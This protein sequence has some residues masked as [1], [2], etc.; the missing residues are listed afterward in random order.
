[1]TSIFY[2]DK[3]ENEY[4]TKVLFLH[5]LEGSSTGS[6]A[7]QLKDSWGAKC[8]PLRT[9]ELVKLKKS[10]LKSWLELDLS[11]IENSMSDAIDDAKDAIRYFQ[12]DIIIGSSMGAA[13]L[14]KLCLD[15]TI[16]TDKT[17]CVFLAP[18]IYELIRPKKKLDLE[19]SVWIFAE[20]DEAVNNRENFNIC[21]GCKGTSIFSKSDT[22]RLQKALNSGLIDN[23]ILT[24]ITK[25]EYSIF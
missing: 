13:V 22:H 8:P 24:L 10:S 2:T 6:K 3:A 21:L 4:P 16:D 5:G 1:M 23:A 9:Q 19:N 12:P 11:D 14:F 17:S 15:K 25:K 20:L 7:N 18:A